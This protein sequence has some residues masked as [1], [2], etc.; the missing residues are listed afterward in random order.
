MTSIMLPDKM[1][2]TQSPIFRQSQ[3]C[4]NIPSSWEH[5]LAPLLEICPKSLRFSICS[6]IE[7]GGQRLTR[8]NFCG[9]ACCGMSHIT[10]MISASISHQSSYIEKPY[11]WHNDTQDGFDRVEAAL[12]R[13]AK[14]VLAWAQADSPWRFWNY[15]PWM[16]P[17][18]VPR[19]VSPI[20]NSIRCL[21]LPLSTRVIGN[22]CCAHCTS[23]C[24]VEFGPYVVR[25]GACAFL[26]TALE[27]VRIPD[28]VVEIG[29]RC[30]F[31]CKRLRKVKIGPHSSLRFVG[32]EAFAM[33]NV[34]ADVCPM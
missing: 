16:E 4:H 31:A 19:G 8:Q 17:Q 3:P 26:G 22:G 28:T 12:R 25:I 9:L 33:T 5:Y 18:P 21:I 29:D 10:S 14:R 34:P 20:Y 32:D 27:S 2:Q 23:I 15:D 11:E 30:F 13:A 1:S 7:Y 24:R 6:T